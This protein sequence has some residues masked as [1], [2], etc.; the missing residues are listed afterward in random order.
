MLSDLYLHVVIFLVAQDSLS[1]SETVEKVSKP[2]KPRKQ[3]TATV[4][5]SA[6]E[7]TEL[8][9][10]VADSK[11]PASSPSTRMKRANNNSPITTPKSS[12]SEADLG[13]GGKAVSPYSSLP[14][15]PATQHFLSKLKGKRQR[16]NS[17]EELQH[18]MPVRLTINH[19]GIFFHAAMRFE[20]QH[21]FFLHVCLSE[22]DAH[23]FSMTQVDEPRDF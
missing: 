7:S 15:L 3:N 23:P 16:Q 9:P 14:P 18:G 21:A 6:S 12:N 11:P 22:Q 5:C 2:R 4:L 1:A 20:R 13:H 19:I 10:H 8:R 17:F